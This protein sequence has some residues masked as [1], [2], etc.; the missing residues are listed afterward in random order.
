MTKKRGKLERGG[1][2][3]EAG[4]REEAGRSVGPDAGGS[5]E[6]S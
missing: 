6:S 4:E 2:G 5:D 1:L 3:G